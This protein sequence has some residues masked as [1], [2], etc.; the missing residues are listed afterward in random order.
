MEHR[1]QRENR[2]K[3]PIMRELHAGARVPRRRLRAGLADLRRQDP[4]NLGERRLAFGRLADAVGSHG[5]HALTDGDG[6]D[7]VDRGV[8]AKRGTVLR[9]YLEQLGDDVAA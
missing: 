1:P 5:R 2:A 3:T 9:R 8:A 6:A 7:L 4:E